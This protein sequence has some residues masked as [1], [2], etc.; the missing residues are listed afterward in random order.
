[1]NGSAWSA[2]SAYLLKKIHHIHRARILNGSGLLKT[3][4]RAS[5]LGV[6]NAEKQWMMSVPGLG[7]TKSKKN[8]TELT[9]DF[10]SQF[11]RIQTSRFGKN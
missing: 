4:T 7:R 5:T 9:G 6:V 2:A 10:P 11:M 3:Q 1:M 8:L